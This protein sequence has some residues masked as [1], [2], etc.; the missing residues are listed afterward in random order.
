[1]YEYIFSLSLQVT[2]SSFLPCDYW[3]VLAL[4]GKAAQV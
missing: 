3:E 2:I 4:M 1:M